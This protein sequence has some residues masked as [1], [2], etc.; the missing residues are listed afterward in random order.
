MAAFACWVPSRAH[1]SCGD[2]IT[3]A[4]DHDLSVVHGAPQLVY[5]DNQVVPDALPH[6]LSGLAQHEPAQPLPCRKCPAAP[7]QAPCQGPWCSGS[8]VPM[9]APPTTTASVLDP[10]TLGGSLEVLEQVPADRSLL[11]EQRGRVHHVFP[12]FHPPRPI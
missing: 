12:V 4:R 10:W 2:Y 8:H 6:R 5:D 9:P 3:M 11:A 1:A 7:G